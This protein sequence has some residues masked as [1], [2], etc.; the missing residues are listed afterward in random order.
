MGCG[1]E[2]KD[3]MLEIRKVAL[4]DAK[5]LIIWGKNR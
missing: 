1:A 4:E 2:I 5:N 3:L